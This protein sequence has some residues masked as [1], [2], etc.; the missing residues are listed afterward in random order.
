MENPAITV[1]EIMRPEFEKVHVD[2]PLTKVS[3]IFASKDIPI[4]VVVEDND[5][6]Y[7]VLTERV[8]LKPHLNIVEAKAGTLATKVPYITRDM[9]VYVVARRMVENNLKALPVTENKKP[10][11]I[12]TVHEIAEATREIL[13]RIRVRD[14]MTANP[15]TVSLSDTIG[16]AISLMRENGISRLPVLNRNKLVGIVTVH[17]IIEKVIKP[18]ERAT[19]GEIVGEK[20]KTLSNKVKDIMST[21]VYTATPDEPL[22]EALDKMRQHDISCLV[23][24]RD[25]SVEGIITMM[26][27]LT[28]LAELAEERKRGIA[29]QV[30]YSK[31]PTIPLED[32]DRV[33]EIAER[34]V[35]KLEDS[36]GNGYLTLY[37]KEHK[38]KHGEM[39]LIHCRARLKTDKYQFVG[40]G[41]AWRADFAAREALSRIERQLLIRKELARRYPYADE[42]LNQLVDF[43]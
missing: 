1:E 25:A 21:P 35:N 43:Y 41:E 31:L 19:R 37:F 8:L 24:S 20:A 27:I 13:R 39:H 3:G 18:R 26:D 36:L 14:V 16:K 29:I 4:V 38:E 2:D 6:L 11:G 34:F 5:E 15:I 10:I 9:S 23:V 22:T 33:M 30:S 42:I 28:P 7:G 17:D 12:V 40:T 32:K